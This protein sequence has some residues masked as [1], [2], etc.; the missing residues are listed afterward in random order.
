M[1]NDLQAIEDYRL[2]KEVEYSKET[3]VSRQSS[4]H[5]HTLTLP[6]PEPS[7]DHSGFDNYIK[8][9]VPDKHPLNQIKEKLVMSKQQ[10]N[11]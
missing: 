8:S 11:Y 1:N 9:M 2:V 5:G 6:S 3:Q 7:R 4:D 10:L